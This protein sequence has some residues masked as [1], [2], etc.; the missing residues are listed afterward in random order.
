[1]SRKHHVVDPGRLDVAL[2]LLDDLGRGAGDR[3]PVGKLRCRELER[4]SDVTPAE[5]LDD[6]R[7]AVRVEPVTLDL[8]A[9]HRRDVESDDRS[10]GRLGRL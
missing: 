1:M 2:D 9:G 4:G 6:R 5:R 10:G 3:E 7:Q 8:L